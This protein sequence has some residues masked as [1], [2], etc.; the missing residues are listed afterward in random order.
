MA[1]ERAGRWVG[2]ALQRDFLADYSRFCST[3]PNV[4]FT[5][6]DTFPYQFRKIRLVKV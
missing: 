3:F 5:E 6:N 4:T 1:H 2:K